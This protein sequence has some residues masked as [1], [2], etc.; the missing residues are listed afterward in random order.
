MPVR[1]IALMLVGML[2]LVA[3]DT[4]SP[5]SALM[6]VLGA[7]FGPLVGLASTEPY[8]TLMFKLGLVAGLFVSAALAMLGWRF[9]EQLW[10]QVV[11]VA[12]IVAWA[13]CGLVGFGP[14]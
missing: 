1:N 10:G 8:F 5:S 4:G 3:L 7:V 13:I 6:L 9:R 14:Q 2:A 12:G 11:V